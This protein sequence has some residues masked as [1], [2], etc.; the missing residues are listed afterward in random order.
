MQQYITPVSVRLAVIVSYFVRR[1]C[2]VKQ[3]VSS[4]YLSTS[5][6]LATSFHSPS[7]PGC[8]IKETYDN[9][10]TRSP[11][12]RF[13]LQ[14]LR[15]EK[16]KQTWAFINAVGSKI[17]LF[18]VRFQYL[19][20]TQNNAG[21][22]ISHNP[23]LFF[24]FPSP[25]PPPG[26]SLLANGQLNGSGSKSG[27][28]DDGSLRSQGL[29]GGKYSEDGPAK[30]RWEAARFYVCVCVHVCVYIGVIHVVIQ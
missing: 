15:Q 20:S 2:L 19:T 5:L 22:S 6:Y 4:L 18:K 25:H 24:S 9:L 3:F 1:L 23:P 16:T 29:D 10:L 26:A 14:Q 21:W 13:L 7:A 11:S 8:Q 30:K 28:K 27:H 17:L 12:T